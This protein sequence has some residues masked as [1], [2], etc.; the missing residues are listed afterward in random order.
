[1]ILIPRPIR[2]PTK[3]EF[4]VL[5][6]TGFVLLVALGIVSLIVGYRAR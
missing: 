1:M 3:A 6:W 5:F 2:P 4:T